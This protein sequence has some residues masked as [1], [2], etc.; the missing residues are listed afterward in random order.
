[1]SA[2]QSSAG[3]SRHPVA[4]N[5]LQNFFLY[6]AHILR[7]MGYPLPIVEVLAVPLEKKTTLEHS[8]NSSVLLLATSQTCFKY[9]WETSASCTVALCPR[10]H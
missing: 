8:K 5:I 6:F 7:I 2:I 9:H 4:G 10:V 3:S 1:M